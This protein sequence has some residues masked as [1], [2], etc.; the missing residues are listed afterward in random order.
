MC[1]IDAPCPTPWRAALTE[2]TSAARDWSGRRLGRCAR[3]AIH[4]FPSTTCHPRRGLASQRL[5]AS[6]TWASAAPRLGVSCA[7]T[8]TGGRASAASALAG[9][10][11]RGPSLPA[12]LTGTVWRPAFE[13]RGRLWCRRSADG[14]HFCPR[15][16]CASTS[17]SPGPAGCG[18]GAL[19][20][21]MV[22]SGLPPLGESLA[23]GGVLVLRGH[24]RH[25]TTQPGREKLPGCRRRV[26]ACVADGPRLARRRR[27]SPGEERRPTHTKASLGSPTRA[28]QAPPR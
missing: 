10:S 23:R 5:C 8:S 13:Q 28:C 24:A 27:R 12:V 22:E 18:V 14:A 25:R 3:Q 4:S 17:V 15:A 19:A 20:L 16:S 1:P 21:A 11:R 7:P 2:A 9:S 26:R 6:G